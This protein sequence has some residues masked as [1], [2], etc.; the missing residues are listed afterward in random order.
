MKV[1]IYNRHCDRVTMANLAQT[2]NVLHGGTCAM[3]G[4]YVEHRA[5]RKGASCPETRARW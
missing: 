3:C 5:E 2:V 1:N 4:C